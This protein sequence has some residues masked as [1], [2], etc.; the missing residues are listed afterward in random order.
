VSDDRAEY[1]ATHI[2]VLEGTA[3]VRKRPG[4][5]VGSTGERGLHHQ[6]FEVSDWAVNEVLAGRAACVDVE[7]TADGRVRVAIDG[8]GI[9][10]EAAGDTGGPSL[11]ALLTRTHAWPQPDGRHSV[12]L[13][14]FGMG[15][16]VANALSSFLTAEVR[17]DGVRWVQHYER[18]VA[19]GPPA[20]AGPTNGP[21]NGSGTTIVFRPDADIFDTVEHSFDTLAERFREL[22]FLNRGLAVSLTDQRSPSRPLEARFIFPGGARDFV[23]FLDARA[24]TSAQMDVL[25][26]EQ[27]YPRMAGSV[28]VALRWSDTPTERIRSFANSAPTPGGGSHVVGFHDGIAAAINAF[29]R[30]RQLLTDADPDLTAD[31][32]CAGLTAVVSVKLDRPEYLGSTRGVLGNP[33]VR[34]CVAHAVREHLGAWLAK[35]PQQAAAVV[36]RM[37][38]RADCD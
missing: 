29:A 25:G 19:V 27:E 22:A 18:G 6:A 30:Q 10:V 12:S 5:Y 21:T 1:D 36:S 14:L 7:L 34:E 8:P 9:P 4:M 16:F 3:A 31:R 11:E 23:A 15:P 20:S 33:A 13:G 24:G 37:S 28:E 38:R 35:A 32:V 17:R 2:Q 26:F